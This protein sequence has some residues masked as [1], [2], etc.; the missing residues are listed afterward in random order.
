MLLGYKKEEEEDYQKFCPELNFHL[1]VFPGDGATVILKLD[2]QKCH[3]FIS[4]HQ[5][6]KNVIE[7]ERKNTVA[8][9]N[10]LNFAQLLD[11][12]NNEA[13]PIVPQLHTMRLI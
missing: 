7:G 9:F 11:S 10:I 4:L 6:A 12:N 2:K 13:V 3:S 5:E 8:L 1:H